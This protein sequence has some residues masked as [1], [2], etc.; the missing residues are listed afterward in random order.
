MYGLLP[1][2]WGIS[3]DKKNYAPQ[4]QRYANDNGIIVFN[5]NYR[6]APETPVSGGILDCYIA[7]KYIFSKTDHFNIDKKKIYITGDSGGGLMA[8]N[9]CIKLV[10]MNEAHLIKLCILIHPM[11][12]SYWVDLPLDK[13]NQ[14]WNWWY[15]KMISDIYYYLGGYTDP[16]QNLENINIFPNKMSNEISKKIPNTVILTSEYDFFKCDAEVLGEKLH[17]NGK[18]LDFIIHPG[19]LHGFY[20]MMSHPSSYQFYED[21]SKIIKKYL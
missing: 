18:L 7:L 10:Q 4:S 8:S 13:C 11:V 15:K 6:L 14:I 1:Q 19:T 16:A 21:I 2:R 20:I 5:V 17:N 9:V 3:L 12:G